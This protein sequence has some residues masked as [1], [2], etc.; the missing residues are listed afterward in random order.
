[1]ERDDLFYYRDC[2]VW[3]LS[4]PEKADLAPVYRRQHRPVSKYLP[5]AMVGRTGS[6]YNGNARP[7]L[8]DVPGSIHPEG[9]FEPRRPQ[10]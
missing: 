10:T 6:W 2:T 4:P 1:M 7:F 8:R 5:A 9:Q 3:L